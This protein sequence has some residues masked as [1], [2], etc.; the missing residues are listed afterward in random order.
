LFAHFYTQSQAYMPL[1]PGRVLSA[2]DVQDIQLH[3]ERLQIPY[4]VIEGGAGISVAPDM[5]AKARMELA[6]YGLPR[7]TLQTTADKTGMVPKTEEQFRAEQHQ[8]LEFDITE[9]LRQIEGVADAYVKIV[10]PDNNTVFAEDKKPSTA[11]VML[12]IVPGYSLSQA[13]IKG[14]INLVSYQVPD[15]APENIA[16]VDTNGISL[17]DSLTIADSSTMGAG[18]TISTDLQLRNKTA[19]EKSMENK[20]QSMLDQVL[21]KGRAVVRVNADI[22]YEQT[23]R[24]ATTYGKTVDISEMIHTEN[25]NASPDDKE[26]ATQMGL[27]AEGKKD[28]KRYK[29]TK[30]VRKKAPSTIKT[31]TIRTAP[32]VKRISASVMVD[33]LKPEEIAKIRNIVRDAIGLNESRGDSLAVESTVFTNDQYANMAREMQMNP[34]PVARPNAIPVQTMAMYGMLALIVALLG[35]LGI[36][37]FKQKQVAAQQS[38]MLFGSNPAEN[39]TDISDLLTDKIGK[40]SP[41][42]ATKVNT[43]EE[44]ERL[45]KEKPTKVAELLK[46]TWLSDKEG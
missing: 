26:D 15:L 19:L 33:N 46:S 13:Q 42:P 41:A 39:T 18:G 3:L 6:K 17:I 7:R 25:Y 14:I 22:S 9:S 36:F 20:V 21:G 43:T 38:Q 31:R 23:E 11:A 35:V 8:K 30:E 44:L 40:S 24:E 34:V 16:I 27:T 32:E 2:K 10:L 37:I 5:K 29:Q 1:Y 45:A 12:R 4:Q 28:A